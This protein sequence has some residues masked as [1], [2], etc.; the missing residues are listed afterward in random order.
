MRFILTSK[1]TAAL[2]WLVCLWFLVGCNT[3]TTET[4]SPFEITQL[5]QQWAVDLGESIAQPPV[6]IKDSLVLLPS[7]TPLLTLKADSGAQ[8]WQLETEAIFWGDSLSATLDDILLAGADGRL[9][10]LSPRSGIMEWEINL[11]GDVLT[12]PLLDRYVLFAATSPFEA[13]SSTGAAVFALNA[14]TGETLWRYKT[15]SA[16]LLTP[17][18]GIDLVYIAGNSDQAAFLYAISAAD[19]KLR[20]EL[21]LDE[22]SQ[23][24]FASDKII[25][26]LTDRGNMHG[27]DPQTGDL[28]WENQTTPNGDLHGLGELIL[29][30]S[31]KKLE[32]RDSLS[33]ELIWQFESDSEIVANA[34]IPQNELLLLNRQGVIISLNMEN[35]HQTRRFATASSKPTGM[36]VQQ[37]WLYLID[38]SG[39]VYA[40]TDP[41]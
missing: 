37:N 27:F 26:T 40:Y 13:E 29:V 39:I 38:G 33:G 31:G 15:H 36:A 3:L 2:N 25:I 34:I 12:P 23:A 28:L 32:A 4:A 7:T 18:R 41:E 9:L 35:G 10:A 21:P 11:E 19:G 16:T 22:P 5:Q 6:L 20:W 1:H 14:S 8:H 17:A 30:T 24:L